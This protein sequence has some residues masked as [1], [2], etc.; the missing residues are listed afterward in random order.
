M[1]QDVGTHHDWPVKNAIVQLPIRLKKK[2]EMHFC[3]LVE[4]I[5]AQNKDIGA[6][7]QMLLTKVKLRLPCRLQRLYSSTKCHLFFYSE[8]YLLCFQ[9]LQT[10][11]VS[12][13]CCESHH[14]SSRSERDNNF[15]KICILC[16][17]CLD[18]TVRQKNKS[19]L[20]IFIYL[21]FGW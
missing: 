5:G 11:Q 17:M 20:Y 9:D 12:Q 13:F 4:S 2:K 7:S 1:Y 6:A 21:D 15:I 8:S 18:L 10:C 19:A 3:Y 16:G 14:F